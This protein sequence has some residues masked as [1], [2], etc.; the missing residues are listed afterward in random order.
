M[1]EGSRETVCHTG[2]RP[3]LATRWS[4]IPMTRAIDTLVL[5]YS[6]DSSLK[7]GGSPGRPTHRRSGREGKLD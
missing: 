7:P 4:L 2:D 6:P 3:P 1:A 5:E